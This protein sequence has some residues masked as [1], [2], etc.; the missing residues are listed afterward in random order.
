MPDAPLVLLID[1]DREIQTTLR[2]V[3]EASGYQVA[4]AGNGRDGQRLIA[5]LK[6]ALVVTD[7]MMPQAG[8]FPVLEFINT[9]AQKPKVIMITANE[10]GRHKA[11][12]EMLGV[13]DYLRKPFAMDLFLEAVGKALGPPP[14]SA[15]P[16]VEELGNTVKRPRPKPGS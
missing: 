15:A 2:G 10:G 12:A 3:L 13:V 9:L 1:D 16:P 7:M 5:E 6:P 14:K 4:S 11:W 8:G